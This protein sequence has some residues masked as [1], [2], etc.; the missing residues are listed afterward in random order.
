MVTIKKFN[1]AKNFIANHL[2]ICNNTL[3]KALLDIKKET[4]S[5]HDTSFVD[6]TVVEKITLFYFVELQVIFMALII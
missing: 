6:T 4:Y 1:N 2:F 3:G 5:F